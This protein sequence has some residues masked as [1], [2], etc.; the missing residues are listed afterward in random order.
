MLV[1][2]LGDEP[3]G[4]RAGFLAALFFV[5]AVWREWMRECVS[6]CV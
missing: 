4:E 5:A 3:A 1:V 2:G 6:V